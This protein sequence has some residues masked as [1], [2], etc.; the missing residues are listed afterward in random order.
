MLYI[1]KIYSGISQVTTIQDLK[2][3]IHESFMSSSTF[4][5]FKSTG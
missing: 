3:E 5:M 4:F 2:I 1:L